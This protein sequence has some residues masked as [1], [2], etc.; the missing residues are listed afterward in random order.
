MAGDNK[1]SSSTGPTIHRMSSKQRR[2]VR[3]AEIANK[4]SELKHE[5]AQRRAR[6]EA[7]AA[8]N[9]TLPPALRKPGGERS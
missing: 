5:A 7:D 3:V 4:L 6:R 8:A 9:S 1:V 2:A